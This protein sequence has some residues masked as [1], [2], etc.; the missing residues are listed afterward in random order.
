MKKFCLLIAGKSSC[1]WACYVVGFAVAMLLL[2]LIW[3][4]AELMQ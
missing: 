3:V 2:K 1:C 4:A